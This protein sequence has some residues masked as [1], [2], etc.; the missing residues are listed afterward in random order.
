[1]EK[2]S[3]QSSTTSIPPSETSS[4]PKSGKA[5]LNLCAREVQKLHRQGALRPVP[6]S[7]V[8][9]SRLDYMSSAGLAVLLRTQKILMASGRGLKL[10]NVNH[11]ILDIFRYSGFDHVFDIEGA[12]GA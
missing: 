9:L 8:D 2:P 11:H 12:A 3:K 10:V 7:T 1:M 5:L 4:K 6:G